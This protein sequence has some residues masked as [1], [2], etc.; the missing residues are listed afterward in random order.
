M[1]S[2]SEAAE[3]DGQPL[4]MADEDVLELVRLIRDNEIGSISELKKIDC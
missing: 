3:V 1:L 2:K 4:S